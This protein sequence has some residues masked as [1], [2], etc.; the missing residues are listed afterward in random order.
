MPIENGMDEE[1][2]YTNYYSQTE[3]E[4]L[5]E[6]DELADA[7]AQAA[8]AAEAQKATEDAAAA[9]AAAVEE[10]AAKEARRKQFLAEAAKKSKNMDKDASATLIQKT[11]R[12]YLTRLRVFR[13]V[14]ENERARWESSVEAQVMVERKRAAALEKDRHHVEWYWANYL[15]EID[16]LK[17]MKEVEV[18]R[19]V[20]TINQ[21]TRIQTR[22][23]MRQEHKRREE[24]LLCEA[25]KRMELSHEFEIVAGDVR[26]LEDKRM[27]HG[28]TVQGT[29]RQHHKD[30]MAMLKSRGFTVKKTA[31]DHIE[32]PD[33]P[34]SFAERS[35]AIQSQVQAKRTGRHAPAAKY[36]DFSL[37]KVQFSATH[38]RGTDIHS[39]GA[40]MN[41]LDRTQLF[42]LARSRFGKVE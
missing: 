1:E 34:S 14:L 33:G 35:R 20:T 12:G 17:R 41:T 42:S 29:S 6:G 24:M 10:A 4:E 30:S 31:L 22:E 39:S 32:L 21:K 36:D 28:L 23:L 37:S 9:A 27:M 15:N 40:S 2:Y 5:G 11:I 3:P 8:A 38:D 25:T 26:A 7:D 18:K 19:S 13:T 16:Q